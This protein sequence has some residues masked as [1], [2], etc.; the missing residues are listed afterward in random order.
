MFSLGCPN[1][2][3]YEYNDEVVDTEEGVIEMV[4]VP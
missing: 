4:Q 3:L 1:E 2:L